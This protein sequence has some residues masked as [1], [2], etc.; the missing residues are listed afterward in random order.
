[1]RLPRGLIHRDVKPAGAATTQSNQAAARQN[2]K[3]TSAQLQQNAALN[4]ARV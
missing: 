3:T 1:M 2:A 4:Q